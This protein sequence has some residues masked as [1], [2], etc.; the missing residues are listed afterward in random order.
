MQFL[1][2]FIYSMNYNLRYQYLN[3]ILKEISWTAYKHKSF[4]FV[5]FCL[6]SLCFFFILVF[7]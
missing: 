6:F 3:I 4:F 1:F 2:V 7:L 5:C